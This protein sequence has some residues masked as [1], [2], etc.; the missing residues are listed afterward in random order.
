M[1]PVVLEVCKMHY[2]RDLQLTQTLL[3]R[4]ARQELFEAFLNRTACF[5]DVGRV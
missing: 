1:T 4:R 5:S 2:Q 3:G